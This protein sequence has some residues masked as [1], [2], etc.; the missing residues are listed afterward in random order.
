MAAAT[1]LELTEQKA[2]LTA[3]FYTCDTL[4]GPWVQINDGDWATACR[5]V[6]IVIQAERISPL[7][8]VLVTTGTLTLDVPDLTESNVCTNVTSA[9]KIVSLTK[10]FNV[11]NLVLL[12]PNR[13][14]TVWPTA[15]S[16]PSFTINPDRAEP[17]AATC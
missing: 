8:D 7:T 4:L 16:K 10:A 2:F 3:I 11:A 14:C 6:K 9:G 5:Y 1:G 13:H 17:C 15:I 12:T